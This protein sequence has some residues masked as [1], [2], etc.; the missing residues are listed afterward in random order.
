[1]KGAWTS[2]SRS[3]RVAN[4]I[5]TARYFAATWLEISLVMYLCGPVLCCYIASIKLLEGGGSGETGSLDGK[6]DAGDWQKQS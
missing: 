3:I 2:F 6:A 5:S 1:M 4:A